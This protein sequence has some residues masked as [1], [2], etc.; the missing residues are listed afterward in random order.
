MLVENNGLATKGRYEK[1][2]SRVKGLTELLTSLGF[3]LRERDEEE[4]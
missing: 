4:H 1:M 2:E 3:P